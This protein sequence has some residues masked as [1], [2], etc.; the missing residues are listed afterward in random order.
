MKDS[1]NTN[2][3]L[4]AATV[5]PLFY[6]T[7]FLQGNIIQTI[8]KMMLD[9]YRSAYRSRFEESRYRGRRMSRQMDKALKNAQLRPWILLPVIFG[10]TLN[11]LLLAIFAGIIS[12]ALSLWAL[13]YQ[14]D[15]FVTREIVLWSMIGL[16]A[17][18][19]VKPTITIMGAPLKAAASVREPFTVKIEEASSDDE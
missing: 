9:A 16:L 10:F 15:S 18:L 11:V 8:T 13:F 4:T 3:Y 1:F 19:L 7:L 14:S 2:F 12:E 5:I 6:I 17:L